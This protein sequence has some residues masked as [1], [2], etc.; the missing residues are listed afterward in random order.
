MSAPEIAMAIERI[1]REFIRIGLECPKE[2]TLS[3]PEQG[4]RFKY[5]VTAD[6]ITYHQTQNPLKDDPAYYEYDWV[7]V[8]GVRV[9]WPI[10]ERRI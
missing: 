4:T 6:L 5:M 7:E 1:R 9:R 8:M 2:I 10:K 3:S